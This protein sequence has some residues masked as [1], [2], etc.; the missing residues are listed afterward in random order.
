MNLYIQNHKFHYELENL[1][2]LFY[3]NEK[4]NVINDA[5]EFVEPYIITSLD[6]GLS[7]EVSI[8]GFNKKLKSGL[9]DDEENERMLC[10]MLYKLLV[11]KT[12]VTPP[13]G[14]ITGVR[15][16]KLYRSLKNQYGVECADN[17]FRD[18]LFVSEKKLELT[19]TT[20]AIEKK[21]IDYIGTNYK[22]KIENDDISFIVLSNI[23][24]EIA[25]ENESNFREDDEYLNSLV[26]K[27]MVKYILNPDSNILEE[28]LAS[29]ELEMLNEHLTLFTEIW[30]LIQ[31]N[32]RLWSMVKDD[33]IK[34]K[35]IIIFIIKKNLNKSDNLTDED[36]DTMVQDVLMEYLT[37]D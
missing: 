11:E 9:F 30:E 1:T 8:S 3:P 13:W 35:N 32:E 21:I 33:Q 34:L 23:A 10:E 29:D 36:K 26:Q 20:E 24:Y 22:D 12:G 16:V 18:K 14:M 37:V 2:R 5:L 25:I 19:K 31:S 4:I 28:I 7:V 27:A 6:S 17:R 15:P